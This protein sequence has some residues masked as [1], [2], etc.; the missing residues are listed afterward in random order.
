MDITPWDRGLASDAAPASSDATEQ[1]LARIRAA[2]AELQAALN[3]WDGG[4]LQVRVDTVDATAI[5]SP[6]RRLCYCVRVVSVA[7]ERLFP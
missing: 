3:G 6:R 5:D 7:S 2:A 4:E 1:T